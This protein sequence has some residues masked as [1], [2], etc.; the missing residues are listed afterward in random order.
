MWRFAVKILLSILL[1]GVPAGCAGLAVPSTGSLV[2][3]TLGPYRSAMAPSQRDLLDHLPPMPAYSIDVQIDPA[4]LTLT[5]SRQVDIPPDP[6]NPLP[7]ELYFRLYPNLPYYGAAM[8]IDLAAVNGQGA[9]FS[10]AASDT[11]VHIAVPPD[12]VVDGEPITVAMQWRLEGRSWP[13]DRYSLFGQAD[14]V[15][16][17]P[18][19][20]PILAV[21]DPNAPDGWRLDLGDVQGDA[22]YSEM[23]LYDVTVTLPENYVVVTSGS[24]VDVADPSSEPAGAGTPQATAGLKTWHM[25]S[26][27]AREFALFVSDQYRL[28]E[29]LAS[30]VRVNSWYLAGDEAS[31]RAAAEYAAAALRIYSELFGPYPYAELDV[32]AGPLTYRGMEYPGLFEL[33]AGLY[34]SNADELEFRIAHEVAHQWW[35]N[36]VGNDPVNVPWLDEGLAEFSTYFYRQKISGQELAE[37]LAT[38]RWQSA[39]EYARDRGLD[40]VVNQPVDAFQGNYEII[41]YGKAALF[42]YAL[43]QA[44]G[45]D[46]YLE[47]LRHY[48]DTYRFG[49]ATPEDFLNLAEEYAGPQAQELYQQWILEASAPPPSDGQA[50][51]AGQ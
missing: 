15:L 3:S 33:G 28:A 29:T 20:Y 6:D 13:D 31:G 17:L 44:M 25:V 32:V 22:A 11:A 14:G 43:L 38:T 46:K 42:Q 8:A 37:R 2:T 49:V 51:Q 23:A 45:Q 47:M 24:L 26:P 18:L 36:L 7:P 41:V 16:S 34:S 21:R 27:P 10:Y 12:A 48:V 40:A 9:P 1:M 19:F 30:D 35:Y 39:F 4:E 50:D 5:G